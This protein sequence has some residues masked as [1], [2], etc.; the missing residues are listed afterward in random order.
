[1]NDWALDG[2]DL[3]TLADGELTLTLTGTDIAGNEAT[4]TFTFDKNTQATI[5]ARFE[6]AVVFEGNTC[7][8]NDA[9]RYLCGVWLAAGAV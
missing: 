4:Q 6:D 5:T 7:V 2:V 1:M 9:V 8:L 3:S